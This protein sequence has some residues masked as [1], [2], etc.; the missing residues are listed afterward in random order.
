MLDF[1]PDGIKKQMNNLKKCDYF[2]ANAI[3]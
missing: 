2:L 1:T 3:T